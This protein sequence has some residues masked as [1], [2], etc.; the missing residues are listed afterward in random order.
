M[1]K[2]L[3]ELI[4]NI[5]SF[6]NFLKAKLS[7]EKIEEDIY[8]ALSPI[9]DADKGKDYVKALNWALN[10]RKDKDIKNIA[11]TGPYG[12]GKSSILK[13]F[14][15]NYSDNDLKF[16]NISLATFKE[17]NEA[18]SP[19]ANLDTVELL[20]QIEIS[21]L[22]QIFYHEEDRKIP[23]SRFKKI[24]SYSRLELVLTGLGYLLFFIAIYNFIEPKFFVKVF[25]NLTF[26]IKS[27][28]V[29]HYLSIVIILIGIFYLIYKSVRVLNSLTINK[30]TIQNA[31]IGVGDNL[32]KSILNHHLDE[33]LYFFSK[34]PYNV[35]IIE[36]LDRFKQTEIFTKL[37]EINLLLNNSEKTKKKNIVFIYA[38]RDEMFTDKERTKFFDFIIPVIP[39]INSSNSNEILLHKNKDNN[40]GLTESFIENISFIIDDMRL[41][42]NICNEYVIYKTQLSSNL[43]SDKL[44]S[45][46]VYKNILP[47]DFVSLSES[48]GLLYGMLMSKKDYVQT[49]NT[50][51]DEDIKLLKEEIIE[52]EKTF[53]SNIKD[54]RK[55]YV[56]EYISRIPKFKSFMINS[57][58]IATMDMLSDQH[59]EYLIN[60][61]SGYYIYGNYTYNVEVGSSKIDFKTIESTVNPNK[62][63]K[64]IEQN[65]DNNNN[66]RININYQKIRDL[67]I[68]KDVN[69]SKKVSELMDAD[70]D[71]KKILN[72][73]ALKNPFLLTFIRN[74]YIAEDY[75][76]YISIFHEGSLTRTDYSFYINIQNR[77]NEEFD[78][79][80]NK[81]LKLIERISLSDFNSEYVLNYDLI[82]K[83]LDN[84]KELS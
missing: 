10:N 62:G 3:I 82:D 43:I 42:H 35:V 74:G 38:V 11:L 79:K 20:R 18:L 17:E 72:N 36:D 63:Y 1:K 28:N 80:L 24:K 30:L 25:K 68:K 14:Q 8:S 65:I 81:T 56:L 48:S 39:T 16:L 69:R 76:D 70:I 75:I 41:L 45:I 19:A 15:K 40:Y 51:I 84:N 37:R 13:T 31:E 49:I 53:F 73:E 4:S 67:E 29:I 64:H 27:L 78:Y 44:F 32:N 7:N 50:K 54:L 26:D 71:L 46:I 5:E 77:L 23:D 57:E 2:K 58:E 21:I 55:L 9:S 47:N 59:F 22:Q 33:I 66:D 83:L 34:R 6:L 60:N 61:E 12:S 52:L